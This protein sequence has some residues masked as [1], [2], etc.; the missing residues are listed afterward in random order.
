[1][2]GIQDSIDYALNAI[3]EI[4]QS[5]IDLP[6][7]VGHLLLDFMNW[8]LNLVPS[9]AFDLQALFNSIGLPTLQMLS[10]VGF[11]QAAGILASALVIRAILMIFG[12]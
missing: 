2:Q 6:F 10:L 8:V 7:I 5:V 11:W 3:K 9:P 4:Y 1:M 12:R